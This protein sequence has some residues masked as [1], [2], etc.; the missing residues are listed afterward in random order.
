M[1]KD[2]MILTTSDE[3]ATYKTVTGWVSRDGYFFGND[4]RSARY[5]GATH[6]PCEECGKPI[7]KSRVRC[8][9]CQEKKSRA[10]FLAM[11]TKEWDR[12]TPLYS[13][14]VEEFFFDE[15]SLL[16]YCDE[17]LCHT[18]EEMELIICEPRY[19]RQLDVDDFCDELPE[20][21]DEA[22]EALMV[23]IDEFNERVKGLGPLSWTPGK[24]RAIVNLST[25]A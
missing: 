10:L 2:K 24:Y 4:E 11:S 19:A 15:E 25:I 17:E 22:P 23:A 14:H 9:E 16:D 6:R 12:E 21:R 20:D 5:S 18:I 8:S 7:E 1:P 13:R 3:A